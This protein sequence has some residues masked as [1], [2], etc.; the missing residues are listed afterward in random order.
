MYKKRKNYHQYYETGECVIVPEDSA[1]PDNLPG[2]KVS[3]AEILT[4]SIWHPS[5]P[6]Y[7]SLWEDVPQKK[8]VNIALM[9]ER[10]L[11]YAQILGPLS[12]SNG[13]KKWKDIFGAADLKFTA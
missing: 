3:Q 2:K 6:S 4:V 11:T 7:L 12:P 1:S 13:P 10:G 5:Q 8:T 9:G